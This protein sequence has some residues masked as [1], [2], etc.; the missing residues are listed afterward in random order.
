M[1][2]I[3]EYGLSNLSVSEEYGLSDLSESIFILIFI[4]YSI[5][6]IKPP[7]KYPKD[8]SNDCQIINLPFYLLPFLFD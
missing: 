6:Y 5:I 2:V 1:S 8:R 3:E 4:K 7:K